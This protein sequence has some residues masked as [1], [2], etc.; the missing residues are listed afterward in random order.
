VCDDLWGSMPID[1]RV[2]SGPV[3]IDDRHPEDSE[4]LWDGGQSW[5]SPEARAG[6]RGAT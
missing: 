3:A 2:E 5:Q 4:S 6:I 1:L